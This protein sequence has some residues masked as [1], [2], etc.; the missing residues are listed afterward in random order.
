MPSINY[1]KLLDAAERT[2]ATFAEAF[3]AFA[4]VSPLSDRKSLL[5]AA[6]AGGIAAGKFVYVELNAY[7]KGA[8][9]A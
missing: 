3:I 8:S 1:A 9:D 4:L 6:A 5:A 7:L 2:T